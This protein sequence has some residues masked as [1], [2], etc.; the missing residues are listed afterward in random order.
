MTN[1]W[2]LVWDLD[3]TLVSGWPEYPQVNQTALKIL[4]LA[5]IA[6]NAGRV[7]AIFL[8]TNN[9]DQEYINAALVQLPQ[10]DGVMDSTHFSRKHIYSSDNMNGNVTK[11]LSDVVQLFAEAGISVSKSDI[12][13][14]VLFFDNYPSHVIKD[15]IPIKH[16]IH[17]TPDFKAG[18]KKRDLTR[19]DYVRKLLLPS[20]RYTRKLR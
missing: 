1:G 16:Y 6:R 3:E 4:E 19:W 2:I 15:E 18:S 10:F 12:K 9:S 14:R 5:D 8:L 7:E 17:I 20:K 13:K 11:G